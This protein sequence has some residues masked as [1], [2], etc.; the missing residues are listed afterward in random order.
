MHASTALVVEETRLK[1]KADWAAAASPGRP[2]VLV[3][4]PRETLPFLRWTPFS[5][6]MPKPGSG[7]AIL[8]ISVDKDSPFSS[9]NHL[10]SITERVWTS[11]KLTL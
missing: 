10:E 3:G 4:A 6:L 8:D 7:K 9:L 1:M 5:R 11:S 2:Q